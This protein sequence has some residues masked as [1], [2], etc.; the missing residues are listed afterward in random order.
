MRIGMQ[1][2]VSRLELMINIIQSIWTPSNRPTPSLIIESGHNEAM[3]EPEE[4][5]MRS[6][7][8][9]CELFS[10]IQ[11]QIQM[12]MCWATTQN[13]WVYWGNTKWQMTARGKRLGIAFSDRSRNQI[14][15]WNK[16]N[17]FN[18]RLAHFHTVPVAGALAKLPWVRV[19]DIGE[20]HFD[21]GL[22]GKE[23]ALP[24]SW[25]FRKF[26]CS[27]NQSFKFYW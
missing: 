24:R 27:Q 16:V 26:Y 15:L 9:P 8:F 19:P 6:A 21:G 17:H 5:T 23:V 11:I 1:L 22:V 14:P 13:T 18:K 10:Q 12:S 20:P 25:N 4:L 7:W 3:L 2:A